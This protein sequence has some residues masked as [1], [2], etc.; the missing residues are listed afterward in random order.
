MACSDLQ[1]PG[2]DRSSLSNAKNDH[3][4]LCII[5]DKLLLLC[6]SKSKMQLRVL[7]P[8]L[9]LEGCCLPLAMT[10][11]L[12]GLTS[13]EGC[14]IEFLKPKMEEKFAMWER[15]RERERETRLE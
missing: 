13:I 5:D 15:E 7:R 6:S 9:P 14:N 2:I 4:Q 11:M 10:A 8:C 12:M 3:F 1:R